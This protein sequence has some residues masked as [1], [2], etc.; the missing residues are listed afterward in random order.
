[1]EP[2]PPHKTR[3]GKKPAS[4]KRARRRRKSLLLGW[5]ESIDLPEWGVTGLVA[6]SDTGANSSAIDVKRIVDRGDGY[7]EF[8]LVLDRKRNQ[9]LHIR[10]PVARRSKIRS[11]TGHIQERYKVETLVRLGPRKK[12]VEF[13]L[14]NR[15]SMLCR[16]LLGRKALSPDF[17]IHPDKKYLLTR[18]TAAKIKVLPPSDEED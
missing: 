18:R 8:D 1:M 17:R 10:T 3:P 15:R 9:I 16:V 5:K 2:S 6:K 12:R 7:V 11:S 13:S 4:R 14:V